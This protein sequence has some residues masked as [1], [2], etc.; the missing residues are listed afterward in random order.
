M[1]TST[2]L[3]NDLN[4]VIS[5]LTTY[6][7][8]VQAYL[9]NPT[10]DLPVLPTLTGAFNISNIVAKVNREA[11][12]SAGLDRGVLV[13]VLHQVD[14]INREVNMRG[15]SRFDYYTAASQDLANNSAILQIQNAVVL[16]TLRGSTKEQ[17]V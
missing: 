13:G 11:S 3:L 7:S 9:N 4:T 12:A 15:M 6:Y 1:E 2:D 16:S 8:A 17:E 5:N 10:L 14:A